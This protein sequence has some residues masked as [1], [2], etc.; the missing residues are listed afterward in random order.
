MRPRLSLAVALPLLLIAIQARPLAVT[1]ATGAHGLSHGL[2]AAAPMAADTARNADAKQSKPKEKL[3]VLAGQVKNYFTHELLEGVK[4]TLLR[5]DS[6]VVDTS[7]TSKNNNAMDVGT[8][9]FLKASSHKA[10]YILRAEMPDYETTYVNLPGTTVRGRG[11]FVVRYVKPIMMKRALKKK[12]VDLDEV[13]VKAT[14]IKFY[15]RGDTIVY[16]ADAFQLSEGS[17][18]DG[19]IR[20]LPGAEL[21][22]DGRIYVNGKYVESLLLNGDDFFAGNNQIMLD[23]L[24]AYMVKQVKVYDKA[25]KLGEMLKGTGRKLGEGQYVMDIHLKRNYQTGWIGNA[26]GGIGTRNRWMGRLFGTRFTTHSRISLFANAN[27]LNDTRRPGE[28]TQW[29]PETMNPGNNTNRQAGLEYN[30]KEK[31]E[32]YKL[33]GNAIFTH[34]DVNTLTRNSTENY[35]TGQSS[36]TRAQNEAANHSWQLNTDHTL[37]LKPYRKTQLSL[38]PMLNYD[39]HSNRSADVSATFNGNPEL[40]GLSPAALLDSISQPNAGSMLRRLAANRYINTA[41]VSGHKLSTGVYLDCNQF[42]ENSLMSS[43][44]L[45]AMFKYDEQ[46]DE[47]RSV[48]RLDYPSTPSLQADYRN[49]LGLTSPNTTRQYELG[50]RYMYWIDESQFLTLD[51]KLNVDSR[52]HD[53][54]LYRLDQLQG[55]DDYGTLPSMRE[56]EQTID[57]NNSFWRS[58][59]D[60]RNTITPAYNY[61]RWQGD[62]KDLYAYVGADVVL[63]NSNMQYKQAAWDGNFHKRTFAINPKV[64]VRKM[65]DNQNKDVIVT[66]TLTNKTP[67]L[68]RFIDVT[69]NEDPLNIRLGNPDLR[70]QRTHYLLLRYDGSRY[71]NQRQFLVSLQAWLYD[72]QTAMGYT[73]N[74]TTGVRVF[75]PMSVDGNRVFQLQA[76]YSA[77]IDKKRLLTLTTNTRASVSRNVDMMAVTDGESSIATPQPSVVT[78]TWFTEDLKLAW[79][80]GKFNVG[81]NGYAYYSLARSHR[82]GFQNRHVW[83]FHYGPTLKAKLP[84]NFGLSTDLMVFSRRGYETNVNTDDFVWNARISKDIPKAHLTLMLDGFDMLR[85]LSSLNVTMNAQGR[86]ET[87]S[88]VLPRYFLFHVVYRF[89]KK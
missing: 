30:I 34:N 87:Y 65:W 66:Y 38:R 61:S 53:Y 72:N 45:H 64:T 89:S 85:Q 46:K 7:R 26:E 42:L 70:T 15:H 78:N 63:T 81:L 52:T 3:C 12:E 33:E 80:L 20:Q 67:D 50:S 18:L 4:V 36:W 83:N 40:A 2:A 73:Y 10:D 22:D 16:N 43:I 19:L 32:K 86:I 88:N 28:S 84:W 41:T 56:Y 55:G 24:P 37:T 58:Q 71:K 9:Y 79:Q 23:N 21:R 5:P 51:Y 57:L 47:S 77:P 48:Y 60:V 11:S 68:V 1:T 27:N 82:Q 39:H 35:L 76:Y 17:M 59:T 75:R 54:R 25:S 49:R 29:T 31:D 44:S 69:T 74:R 6:S 14:K 8:V 13:V 62:N